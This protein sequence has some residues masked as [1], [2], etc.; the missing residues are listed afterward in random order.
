MKKKWNWIDVAVLFCII[1][2]GLVLWK[3]N[4][5]RDMAAA[6]EKKVRFTCLTEE[7][8]LGAESGIHKGDRLFAQ[9]VFQPGE[10][11][12]VEIIPAPVVL[13]DASG[14]YIAADH[15]EKNTVLVTM[16]ADVIY[17][18]PYMQLGGQEVKAGIDYIVKTEHFAASGVIQSCEV[19]E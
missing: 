2:A 9:Y 6:P 10:V 7:L 11:T 1:A 3:R 18:G 15:P 19:I 13:T 17:D 8:P 16:E 14:H 4:A 12:D 5:I